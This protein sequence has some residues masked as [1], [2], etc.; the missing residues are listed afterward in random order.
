VIVVV[1]VGHGLRDT[2]ADVGLDVAAAV[3]EVVD[4]VLAVVDDI[5]QELGA[6]GE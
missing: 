3:D 1:L 6:S 4:E 2:G 5:L